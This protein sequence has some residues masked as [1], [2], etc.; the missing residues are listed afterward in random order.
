MDQDTGIGIENTKEQLEVYADIEKFFQWCQHRTESKKRSRSQSPDVPKKKELKMEAAKD[1]QLDSDTVPSENIE[2]GF[3]ESHAEKVG[4]KTGPRSLIEEKLEAAAPFN[5]FL[6][7]EAI[8][9]YP[10]SGWG[11][12]TDNAT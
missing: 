4:F 6:T 2:P 5:F 9:D 10:D 7:K 1:A 11:S 8:P 3:V 12:T